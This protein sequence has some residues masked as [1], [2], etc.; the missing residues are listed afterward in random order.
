V[1]DPPEIPVICAKC[2][3][4][5]GF[6]DF[7]GA[8]GTP[9]GEVNN[10]APIGTLIECDA[11]HNDVAATMNRV[12]MPSG[13]ELKGLGSEA[14]CI[15]CHQGR[16]STIRVN[17]AIEEADVGDDTVSEE[18]GLL[19]IHYSAN[20]AAATKYGTLAKGGYEYA[21]K[22]YF[23]RN[24]HVPG[25]AKCTECHGTHTLEVQVEEC[26]KC[27]AGVDSQ[28]DLEAIR[29]STVDYDGDGDTEEGIAGEIDGMRARL[30]AAIQDYARNV[31]G[32]PIVYAPNVF[33]Y[34]FID[35]NGN[36]QPDEDETNSDSRYNAWTP[37][38][39]KASY[40]YHVSLRDPGA[41]A[42][43]APYILQLLYDSIEDLNQ[44]VST[45]IDMSN[46]N[47]PETR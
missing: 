32:T 5:P 2:H 33:P 9:A 37:R 35:T 18:F 20:V 26:G 23:G 47:R 14:V 42:H 11:C 41:Y 36:G 10:P 8:D 17:S 13:A 25:Y 34:F 30:Y 3:S 19:N 44:A 1:D 46:L 6:L 7:I 28:E 43:G 27:H 45:P 21:G 4:T 29:M 39:W 22:E 24:V 38:L 15:Q 12:V 31:T 40:N 16:A